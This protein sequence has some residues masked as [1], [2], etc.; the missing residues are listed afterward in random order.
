MARNPSAAAVAWTWSAI[1]AGVIASLVVQILLVMLGIGVGLLA[2]D[3]A[4]A[5]N[6]PFGVTWVAF[7]WWAASGIFAAFIGGS[8]AAMHAPAVQQNVRISHAVA[9]WALATVLVVGAAGLSA[10]GAANIASNLAGPTSGVSAQLQALT[11]TPANA[12]QPSPQQA[13]AARRALA[14]GMFASFFALLLG[15]GAAY[16]GGIAEDEFPEWARRRR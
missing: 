15:A 16:L 5:A 13:E 7:L 10:G 2:L 14:A 11:R 8:V 1:F 12:Q 4:A 3:T 9:S 6:S